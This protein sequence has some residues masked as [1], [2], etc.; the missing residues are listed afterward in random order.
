M[1]Q[2]I[3]I[4]PFDTLKIMGYAILTTSIAEC[5]CCRNYVNL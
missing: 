4:D 3:G 5:N 1:T 2:D